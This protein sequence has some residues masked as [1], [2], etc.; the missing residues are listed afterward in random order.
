ML[1]DDTVRG[2]L[3]AYAE[4]HEDEE[5]Q[6]TP[7]MILHGLREEITIRPHIEL[8]SAYHM[9]HYVHD[10]VSDN[11]SAIT[12]VGRFYKQIGEQLFQGTLLYHVDRIGSHL[13][14]GLDSQTQRY[15]V[16]DDSPYWNKFPY[17]FDDGPMD[18]A[19][20]IGFH[21]GPVGEEGEEDDEDQE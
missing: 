21:P 13:L 12:V 4:A 20:P 1:D 16:L 8:P 7:L 14:R 11:V 5:G 18:P 3:E 2:I 10:F 15:H 17:D 19:M 9:A 6:P